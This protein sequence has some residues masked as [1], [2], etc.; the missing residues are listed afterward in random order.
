MPAIALGTLRMDSVNPITH[1]AEL[2]SRLGSTLPIELDRLALPRTMGVAAPASGIVFRFAYLDVPFT[3]RVERRG[4]GAVLRLS[5]DLG[6][7]PF[8]IE[9]AQC[10]RRALRTLAAATRNTALDW[11]VSEKQGITVRGEID[12]PRPLTPAAMVGGAVGL[13]LRGGRYLDLL[14][15]VL[16][17]AECLNSPQ[18]A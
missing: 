11:H 4:D 17:E 10:R 14:V 16:G 8:T 5:G 15:D 7:L 2:I 12:L 13:L 3:G 9:A 18:A 6:P 1:H